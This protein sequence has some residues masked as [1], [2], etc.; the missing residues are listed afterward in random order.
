VNKVNKLPASNKHS[1][2]GEKYVPYSSVN[3]IFSPD[4]KL[5]IDTSHMAKQNAEYTK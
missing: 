5:V 1:I 2:R 4:G 3:I